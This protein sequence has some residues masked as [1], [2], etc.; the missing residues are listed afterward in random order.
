MIVLVKEIITSNGMKRYV[1]ENKDG[2]I[3]IPVVKYLKYLDALGRARNTIKAYASDLNIYFDYLEEQDKD[4]KDIKLDDLVNFLSYLNISSRKESSINRI[5]NTVVEFYDYSHRVNE[6]NKDVSILKKE[7][8]QNKRRF[9]GFL[10]GISNQRGSITKI[11]K[12]RESKSIKR[13]L[14]K[15]EIQY[16]YESCDNTRDRFLIFLLWETSIR[17]GEALSLWIEDFK[18]D[19]LEIHITDRGQLENDAEIK[20]KQSERTIHVTQDLMNLFM[21]YICEY[22]TDEVNTNF[23]FIK[24]TGEKKNYPLTYSDV[25]Y[26]FKRL[27]KKTNIIDLHPHIL[28][29]SSLTYYARCGLRKEVLRTRSGHKSIAALHDYYI[30]PTHEE[31]LEEWNNINNNLKLKVDNQDE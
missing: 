16:I 18:F 29:R 31:L 27:K 13:S 26:V 11:L 4:Y 5:M 17:I 30:I 10:H 20:N 23:V 6:F 3:I 24:I 1:V 8:K 25:S 2:D 19:K 7:D 9:N 28:R 21:E 14:N 22:H 15:D 12:V